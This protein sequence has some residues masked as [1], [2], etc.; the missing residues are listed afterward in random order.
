MEETAVLRSRVDQQAELILL[1]K[2]R[3]ED[4]EAQVRTPMRMRQCT[5][6]LPLIQS[7]AGV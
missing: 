1:L 7:R 4:A 2:R 3:A 5:A 6:L